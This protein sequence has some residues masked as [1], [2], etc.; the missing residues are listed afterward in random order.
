MACCYLKTRYPSINQTIPL[1]RKKR[2]PAIPIFFND[3]FEKE[4]FIF[5]LVFLKTPNNGEN[6][7]FS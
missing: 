4:S 6:K 3:D 5:D 2:N 1:A 7:W